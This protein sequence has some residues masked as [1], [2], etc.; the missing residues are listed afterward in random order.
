MAYSKVLILGGF[1]AASGG[2][3]G[4]AYLSSSKG[5]APEASETISPVSTKGKETVKA[6]K[7]KKCFIYITDEAASRTPSITRILS[8][9][10]NVKEFLETKKTSDPVFVTDVETACLGKAKGK[11]VDA[12]EGINVYV[13]EKNTNAGKKWIYS[14]RLQKDWMRMESINKDAVTQ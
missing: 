4:G 8:R 11:F 7:E 13:Y 9:H 1:T 6:P 14:E 3:T 12:A 5:K 10:E 2:I